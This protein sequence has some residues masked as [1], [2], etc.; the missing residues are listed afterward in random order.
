V[1]HYSSQDGEEVG[2]LEEALTAVAAAGGTAVVQAA[3]T[4]AWAV[5]RQAVGR[6]FGRGDRQRERAELERLDRS[7]AEL[8]A[9]GRNGTAEQVRV[10]H[11]VVWQT[12]FETVLEALDEKGQAQAAAELRALLTDHAPAPGA[13]AERGGVAVGGNAH[14]HASHG[15]VTA[16][17]M[18]NVTLGNP[19]QPGPHRG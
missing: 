7:A 3:G 14:L 10:R 9:A 18:G 17:T 6:W 5:F 15:S 11:T 13:S 4:D 16:V 19:P 1:R 8:A 12:R 2:V